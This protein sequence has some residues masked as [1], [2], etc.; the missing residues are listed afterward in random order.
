[1]RK[2]S[3]RI[4]SQVLEKA[5][6]VKSDKDKTPCVNKKIKK[7]NLTIVQ[8]QAKHQTTLMKIQE[9]EGTNAKKKR[10]NLYGELAKLQ[11]AIDDPETYLI[12]VKGERDKIKESQ[13]K[14]IE[15]K[16]VKKQ[17][18]FKAKKENK[19]EAIQEKKQEAR[20]RRTQCLYC[21]KYGHSIKECNQKEDGGITTNKCYNCGNL[22]HILE[23]CPYPSG[24]KL[25]FA[26]CFICHESGHIAKDCKL[27]ENGI[28][29]KGGCCY[30]CGSNMH[31]KMDCPK[32]KTD[33]AK[34]KRIERRDKNKNQNQNRHNF[35][36]KGDY[37]SYGNKNYDEEVY[38]D[39][40][41]NIQEDLDGEY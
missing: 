17:E 13:K 24:G 11:K 35:N 14:R 27:N 25:Q 29:P 34:K 41:E 9:C 15:K 18:N 19:K 6:N 20:D 32:K 2:R 36:D 22:D 26:N 12:N 16:L 1:M 28:Y 5:D 21:K 40:V 39:P 37:G 3:S 8:V 31:K 10:S 38:D 4:S 33:D 7:F 23:D 30:F